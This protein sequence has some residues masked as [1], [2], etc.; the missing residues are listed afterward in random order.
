MVDSIVYLFDL[1]GTMVFAA[2]GAIKGVRNRLDF[3]GVIVFLTRSWIVTILAVVS[4][5]AAAALYIWM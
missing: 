4:V 1:F 3:L 5:V 2:T